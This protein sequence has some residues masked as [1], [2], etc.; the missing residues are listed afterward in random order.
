VLTSVDRDD[1][2][3]GGAYHF[4]ETISKIKQKAPTM[5]VEALTGDYAGDLAM[6]K[7]VAQSGLDVYAH[8]IETVEALTPQVR[9]RRAHFRQSLQVLEAA[10]KAKEGLIT[11]TSIMLG[12]GESEEQ[13]W[14]A[15]RGE[16]TPALGEIWLFTTDTISLRASECG[17]RRRDL[18]SIYETHEAAH[19]GP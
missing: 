4:A 16:S 5:L 17:C 15:L 2:S 7:V 14:H 13:L 9:D 6:V 11:K 18:W 19:E 3:D 8:N 12:L 10:K 1:L